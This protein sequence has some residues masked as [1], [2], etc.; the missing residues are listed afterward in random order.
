MNDLTKLTLNNGIDIPALGLGV[1]Q[2]E[3]GEATSAVSTAVQAGYR[4]I[5]TGQR[6]AIDPDDATPAVIDLT[7][8]GA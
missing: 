1:L 6:G 7:I 8:D 2:S 5:D 4:L 3:G